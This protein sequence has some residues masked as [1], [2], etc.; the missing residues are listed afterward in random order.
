MPSRL[1]AELTAPC[2]QPVPPLLE[3]NQDLAQAYLASRDSLV[4]CSRLHSDLVQALQP[5]A[6][7]E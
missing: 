3:T 4:V 1:P 2:P 5:P 7:K 6:K